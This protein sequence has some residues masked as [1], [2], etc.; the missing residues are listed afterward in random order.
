[1]SKKITVTDTILRDSHQSL[2]ATRMRTEDMRCQSAASWIRLATGHWKSGAVQ[3]LI[4]V[5]AS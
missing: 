3:H 2:L 1:M 4:P 5:Y